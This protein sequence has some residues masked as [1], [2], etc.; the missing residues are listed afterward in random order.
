MMKDE[1]AE[2]KTILTIDK[3]NISAAIRRKT[4]APDYRISASVL[5]CFGITLLVISLS[6]IVYAD[7]TGCCQSKKK[8]RKKRIYLRKRETGVKLTVTE[9]DTQ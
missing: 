4:S 2:L 8:S 9:V 3:S 7:C 6:L 1:L 5:G